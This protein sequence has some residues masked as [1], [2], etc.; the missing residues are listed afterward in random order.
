MSQ[1][2]PA[3][4]DRIGAEVT[5]EARRELDQA[6]T[7]TR[8]LQDQAAVA[9]SVGDAMQ[10]VANSKLQSDLDSLNRLLPSA[11]PQQ[12]KLLR[13]VVLPNG[14]TGRHEMLTSAL[15]RLEVKN[16]PLIAKHRASVSNIV[17]AWD[18]FKI[19]SKAAINVDAATA[20]K[21]NTQIAQLYRGK[22]KIEAD[23]KR[24]ELTEEAKRRFAKDPKTLD[25]VIKYLQAH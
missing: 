16:L 3:L 4:L 20:Q 21:T 7:P 24:Q 18:K 13:G 1:E 22:T 19:Q 17:T 6:Q 9:K 11:A 5:E 10:A 14:I 8:Q 15:G 12:I 23:K 2:I 25:Q